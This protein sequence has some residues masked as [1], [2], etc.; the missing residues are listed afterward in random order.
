MFDFSPYQAVFLDLDG[1]LYKEEQ[2]LPGAV[3]LL[4]RLRDQGRMVAC[5]TNAT[6]SPQR[7]SR[8]LAGMGIDLPDDRIF[9]AAEAAV[10]YCLEKFAPRPRLFN[11]ATEG[12]A[13][14]LAGRSAEVVNQQEP[15]DAVIIG[16]P[17]CLYATP[18]RMS[19]A[20]SLLRRG[21]A[22]VG[23][24]DDR[25]YPS[26]R[27][28]E[29]GSGAMTRMLAYAANVEPIFFGKPRRNFFERICGRL[30]VV[31]EQCV[32]IGDNLESDIAGAKG[33]GMAAILVL[34]GVAR[35]SDVAGLSPRDRP[36]WVV[37][38]LLEF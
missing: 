4:G 31:A 20:L 19:V 28:W 37:K 17:Q 1:T 16:N 15:C 33:V 21:A 18:P 38:D 29:I 8:R 11:L 30:G 34:T 3:A 6:Q 2:P 5:P 32:L 24:C 35:E 12:V 14:M 13:D 23:I 26:P 36:D 10:T 9:T 27:G 7:L 25:L 22:C